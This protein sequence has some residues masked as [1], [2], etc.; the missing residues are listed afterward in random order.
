MRIPA[1]DLE[2][3]TDHLRIP[4]C[5]SAVD[6]RSGVRGPTMMSRMI[7]SLSIKKVAGGPEIR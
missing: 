6:A 1:S 2:P 7:P 4:A 5:V 3:P